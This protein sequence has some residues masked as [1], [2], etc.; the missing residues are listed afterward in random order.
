MEQSSNSCT[1]L[2]FIELPAVTVV[3]VLFFF[4][5]STIDNSKIQTSTLCILNNIS[6]SLSHDMHYW[7]NKY[8][9]LL[10][11]LYPF[12]HLSHVYSSML[13]IQLVAY[14]FKSRLS[15]KHCIIYHPIDCESILRH[16]SSRSWGARDCGTTAG[17][18]WV[19]AE[20]R[21]VQFSAVVNRCMYAYRHK[22]LDSFKLRLKR[23]CVKFEKYAQNLLFVMFHSPFT[24][25]CNIR[26]LWGVVVA[27]LSCLTVVMILES[28][29]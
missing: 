10:C 23:S 24:V 7:L 2:A 21:P 26:L 11:C 19:T 18:N 28:E 8:P 15:I 9:A 25:N 13:P 4:L 16:T 1:F 22:I 3:V 29:M 20:W 6:I 14:F 27:V 17:G 12:Q 5:V